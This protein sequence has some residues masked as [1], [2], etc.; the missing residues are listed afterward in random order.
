VSIHVTALKQ[1]CDRLKKEKTKLGLTYRQIGKTDIFVCV[2]IH[3]H[4]QY[5]LANQ[6]PLN[7]SVLDLISEDKGF[8][9]ELVKDVIRQPRTIAFIDPEPKERFQSY[10]Q[11]RSLEEMADTCEQAFAFPFVV[12]K[13][14]GSQGENVF[15]CHDR[16]EVL[17]AFTA[18]FNKHTPAY[19]HVALVQERVDIDKEYRV[20]VLDQKIELVYQK[21]N[22]QA[23]F[24]G[25]LSPLHWDGAR[26]VLVQ[27]EAIWRQLDEFIRPM[28]AVF[29]LVY[30][31]L[32]I[33]VDKNGKYWLF[34]ANCRPAYDHLVAGS[35]L[36]VLVGLYE[37][38]LRLLAKKAV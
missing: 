31:G 33:A 9:Y 21:D 27:D 4:P 15:L 38:I 24:V 12:K 29:P 22:S 7:N 8:T 28:F 10:V 2:E 18:I 32:D 34:E 37:K 20:T 14:T 11:Q 1:A 16:Q 17:N 13:N 3:G 6:V 25:N 35:D 5:F 36:S 23:K 30:G 26:A 19:D